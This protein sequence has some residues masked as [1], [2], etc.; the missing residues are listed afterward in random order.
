MTLAVRKGTVKSILSTLSWF[1][2]RSAIRRSYSF[3]ARLSTEFKL[4]KLYLAGKLSLFT[5]FVVRSCFWERYG[6]VKLHNLEELLNDVNHKSWHLARHI[7]PDPQRRIVFCWH[8]HT[9]SILLSW[10][11]NLSMKN[12]YFCWGWYQPVAEMINMAM[13][14]MNILH[15]LLQVGVLLLNILRL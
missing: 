2:V 13:I 12:D 9:H 5:K 14:H 10:K 4:N 7:V 8:P 1:I 6:V 15:R 3:L 11:V